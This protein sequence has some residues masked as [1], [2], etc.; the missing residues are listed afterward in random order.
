M[1]E[2]F[3]GQWS[4]ER[5]WAW[6]NSH[7][8]IRGFNYL[9]SNCTT[10]VDM[11]QGYSFE[12][13]FAHMQREIP[14]AK[15]LGFN[16]IR[17]PMSFEVWREERDGYMERFERVLALLHENGFT[18]NARFGNDCCGSKEDYKPIKL[19]K[20]PPTAWGY[21]GGKKPAPKRDDELIGY[22]PID[23]NPELELQYYEWVRDIISAHKDDERILF[24]GIWNEAGNS[25]RFNKSEKY[26]LKFFEIAREIAPVQPLSADAWYMTFCK[27]PLNQFLE[28]R[29]I[30]I[31]M[32]EASDIITFHHYGSYLNV[33][34]AIKELKEKYD[35]PIYNTEWLHRIFDNNVNDLFPLFYL[36]K[37]GSY[38]YGFIESPAQY[39]EPWE[40]LR[41][42]DLPIDRWQHDI[43]RANLRPY[44]HEEIKTIKS[45]C[46]LADKWWKEKGK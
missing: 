6:H 43:L 22:L 2:K 20:Q 40:G 16:S 41:E 35:R 10:L 44:S 11:W 46:A 29:E 31:L 4:K 12:E 14:L 42:S 39:Y 21:H 7:P 19:G 13:S 32:L 17:M 26:I 24:W 5:A 9:P 38:H 25:N 15:E 36:E 27:D 23:D 37:I 34:S 8:W 30:E 45:V 33:V 18:M 1:A 3:K 28:C